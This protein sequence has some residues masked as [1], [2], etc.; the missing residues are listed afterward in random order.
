MSNNNRSLHVSFNEL[1]LFA[2][3]IINIQATLITIKDPIMLEF[4]EVRRVVQHRGL[5]RNRKFCAIIQ[6]SLN[7]YQYTV[8]YFACELAQCIVLIFPPLLKCTESEW[9]HSFNGG[10]TYSNL[11]L[12][13]ICLRNTLIT[14]LVWLTV[15]IL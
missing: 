15:E 9:L 14:V 8:K 6:L 13:S 7:S 10:W 3:W 5:S 4:T 11:S 2:A 12:S 1:I